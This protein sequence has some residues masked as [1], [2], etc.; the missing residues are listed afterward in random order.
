MVIEA[1]TPFLLRIPRTAPFVLVFCFA[2]NVQSRSTAEEL[3]TMRENLF[4]SLLT[5]VSIVVD[6]C[7][8][9]LSTEQTCFLRMVAGFPLG[10]NLTVALNNDDSYPQQTQSNVSYKNV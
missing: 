4:I 3:I 1:L 9:I 6:F 5:L 8:H 10:D 7:A 2:G